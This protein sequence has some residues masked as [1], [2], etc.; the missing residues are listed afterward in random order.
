MK[1]N[2]GKYL[3]K[4]IA[5]IEKSITPDARIEHDVQMPLLNSQNGSTTQCDIVIWSGKKPRETITIIEVQDRTSKIKPNDFRGWQKKLDEIG[6]QHLICVSRKPFPKSIKENA[7]QSGNKIFLMNIINQMPDQLPLTMLK[8]NFAYRHFELKSFKNLNIEYSIGELEKKSLTKE[9]VFKDTTNL[10]EKCYSLDLA[11]L[12]SLYDICYM[13]TEFIEQTQ[14][15]N[16]FVEFKLTE[17][18][19][20]YIYKYNQFINI[21]LNFEFE[22]FLEFIPIP[23]NVMTYEQNGEI[24]AWM[25]ESSYDLPIGKTELKV[26]IIPV[27]DG[28]IIKDFSATLPM[29]TNLL[30]EIKRDN[31]EL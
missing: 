4:L 10:N 24:L 28:F 6:A 8:S 12:V 25:L 18:P 16:R 21:G 29:D 2:D 3:E 7:L 22:Y 11:N 14:E 9:M 5:L 15:Q 20:I 13:K 17:E 27:G 1:K 19:K 26:P 31:N 30:M 23:L